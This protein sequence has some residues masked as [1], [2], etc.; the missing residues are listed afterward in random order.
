MAAVAGSKGRIATGNEVPLKRSFQAALA[1]RLLS[2]GID[3]YDVAQTLID[4]RQLRE[5]GIDTN[6]VCNLACRYCYLD[7]RPEAKGAIHP[8]EWEAYLE[9]L[10]Q[11]GSKLV[12]FIGKEPLADTI[13]LD[14]ISLLNSRY[15]HERDFRIGMVTNGTFLD[16]RL[17]AIGAAQ[18]DYLDVSLDST[19]K[20][21]DR[22][23]GDGV[24]KR[25]VKNLGLYL[26]TKPVHDF[27]ITSVLHK[28]S[29]RQYVN[30]V[31][32]L[33]SIGI[34]TAFGS[35]VLRF[36]ERDTAS[37]MAASVGDLKELFDQLSNYL[38]RLS[39]SE[40]DGRQIIIDL[41][42][43]YSWLMLAETGFDWSD[44]KQDCFE[45]H[46]LL[47]A[48]NLPLFIKFNFFPMSYW[49]AIRV[50]HDARVIE[51]MDLAAH[52][53]YGQ[54]SRHCMD[55]GGRWYFGSEQEYHHEFLSDFARQHCDLTGALTGVH[56]REVQ[57]QF[58][59]ISRSTWQGAHA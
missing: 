47:P 53:L 18:L 36:T 7:D 46:F 25:V 10:I 11:A 14:T 21:N 13:A 39:P 59:H 26:A 29:T 22:M 20:T 57:G 5:V 38:S 3:A 45:A 33:F 1:G 56:D 40:R 35:P 31:D 34:K 49:R 9:P 55:H 28:E 23:R 41:P 6:M 16:R 24:F 2:G 54:H 17:D 37:G 15:G 44:I 43:K 50:T 48:V 12:A 52:R 58:K 27:S 19:E 30:F 8:S 4:E 51:N 42:Y 32:F